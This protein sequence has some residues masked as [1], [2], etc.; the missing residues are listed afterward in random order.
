MSKKL[1]RILLSTSLLIVFAVTAVSA[2]P[3]AKGADFDDPY[4][5]KQVD[6]RMDPLTQVQAEQKEVALNAV[7]NGKAHGKTHEVARGQF[8]ELAR[9]G[10]DP[11]W[12]VLGEFGDFAHNSI[13]EPDRATD[14]TT[15]WV[16]DFSRDHYMDLLFAEGK[17][18]ISMRQWYIEQSSNRY[19]VYGD[20]T[21]WVVAPDDACS[22]DDDDYS[23]G[24]PGVW[25]FMQDTVD[26]W[27]CPPYSG[28]SC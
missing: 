5:A 6:Y 14:N 4:Y 19:A 17:D 8:V 12:T 3:G 25:Q 21:D 26:E 9:Q 23:R 2:A 18:V 24:Y 15:Y 11:V 10:E 13:A 1:F 20:V 7:L 27:Y 28:G 16:E 22:Y